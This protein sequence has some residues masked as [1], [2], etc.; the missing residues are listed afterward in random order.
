MP[1][2]SRPPARQQVKQQGHRPG[3]PS[4]RCA[5]TCATSYQARGIPVLVVALSVAAQGI[6]QA[7]VPRSGPSSSVAQRQRTPRSTSTALIKLDSRN[8]PRPRQRRRRARK[9]FSSGN[10]NK[11]ARRVSAATDYGPDDI[12]RL[13]VRDLEQHRPDDSS[14]RSCWAR[15]GHYVG[16]RDL[17]LRID[18]RRSEYG[19]R[20]SLG[21]SRA[22][23]LSASAKQRTR[24]IRSSS[25]SPAACRSAT[26]P[27]GLRASMQN[28]SCASA[29]SA[30]HFACERSSIAGGA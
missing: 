30:G 5:R 29:R 22:T 25:S 10:C 3:V 4:P 24:R 27:L 15:F 21:P 1:R 26:R 16:F 14:S 6:K 7:K 9:I 28:T 18:T 17:P 11:R 12:L 13:T 2:S 8:A 23:K 20:A 19:R